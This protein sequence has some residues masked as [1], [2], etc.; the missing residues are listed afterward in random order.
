MIYVES[1][2]LS[3]LGL[4]PTSRSVESD[5]TRH[6]QAVDPFCRVSSLLIHAPSCMHDPRSAH[7]T[8]LRIYLQ[9]YTVPQRYPAGT[10]AHAQHLNHVIFVLDNGRPSQHT[11]TGTNISPLR[12]PPT[13]A[14]PENLDPLPT[15]PA[16]GPTLLSI[17]NYP[18]S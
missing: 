14:P 18:T 9:T 1:I 7:H 11:V 8:I 2:F 3:S 6:P 10:P 12:V 13:R 17:A 16:P 4:A 5:T 15:C